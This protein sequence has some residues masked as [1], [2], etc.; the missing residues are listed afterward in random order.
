MLTFTIVVMMAV[1]GLVVDLGWAYYRRQAAQ[2]AADAAVLAA[3]TASNSSGSITCGVNGIACQDSASCGTSIPSPPTNNLQVGCLYAQSN[4]FSASTG[5]TVM[6]SANTTSPPPGAP[7]VQ[8]PYWITVSVNETEPQTFSSILGN[9][10]M[11]VGAHATASVFPIVADCI[12]ALAG[13]GV[14]LSGN[15]NISI[16][17]ACGLYV[18]SSASNAINLVGNASIGVTGADID[19]VGNWS[20]NKNAQISPTPQTGMAVA[21][22]PLGG[23]PAPSVGGCT[24][25]GI[26]LK[27]HDTMT[28][29]PGVYCGAISVGGQASLTLN[30]GTYVL[31]NGLSLAGGATLSG[32]GVTLYIQGGGVSV[33]GGGTVSL[34][35][36]STG[37]YEGVAIFQSRSNTSTLSLVGGS[38]QF[39]NGAVYAAAADINYTGGASGQSLSTML[40]AN[41]ISFVGNSNITAAPKT[42][43][44]GGGGGPT[45]IQ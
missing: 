23:M 5:Q 1:L 22:D 35:A 37:M 31:E 4:G 21:S 19:I 12:Y 41:T 8:V 45:L 10:F 39:V 30:P 2:A 20:A 43:Y 24:S 17:T 6:I 29:N 13:T 15:G 16:N 25:S 26:S 28:A 33:A 14:G 38:T 40:V 18:D 36:P 3:A 27:S 34:T 32:T 9:R 7:G 11:N 44:N 42:G